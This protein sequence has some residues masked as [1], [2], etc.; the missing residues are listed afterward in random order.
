MN[1]ELAQNSAELESTLK[2]IH[3]EYTNDCCKR[4]DEF[5]KALAG[6][7]GIDTE[8]ADQITERAEREANR[9]Q[10]LVENRINEAKEDSTRK[11]QQIIAKYQTR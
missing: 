4:L 7:G 11:A 5:T 10:M 9:A 8:E 3:D 6:A 2:Q 1:A